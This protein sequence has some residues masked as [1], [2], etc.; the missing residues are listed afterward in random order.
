MGLPMPLPAAYLRGPFPVSTPTPRD[1]AIDVLPR[2]PRR[3]TPLRQD[4]AIIYPGV[5]PRYRALAENVAAAITARGGSPPE[6]VADT[7]LIPNRS[8]PL[9]TAYRHRELIVLG[10]LNTNGALLPLYADYL[11]SADA[12]YPGDDGYD[13]RT[14]V[15]PY[16]TGTNVILAG[17]SSLRGVERAVERLIGAISTTD[18]AV[19]LPFVLQVEIEAALAHSSRRGPTR[20]SRTLPPCRPRAAADLCSS[21]NRSG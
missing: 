2:S 7:T 16:G 4:V 19:N 9:P 14:I 10:N 13:L 11:C 5:H 18:A 8:T 12:T 1:P 3:S 15:N 17:G 20:R 6:C 21:P